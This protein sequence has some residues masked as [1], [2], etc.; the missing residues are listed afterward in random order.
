MDAFTNLSL[1]DSDQMEIDPQPLAQLSLT[2]NDRSTTTT[3]NTN[4]Y[5]N[6]RQYWSQVPS[7][8][9][10]DT[11]TTN[12]TLYIQPPSFS[13]ENQIES[14]V[15]IDI[16]IDMLSVSD[17]NIQTPVTK[18]EKEKD[19]I[20]EIEE[21]PSSTVHSPTVLHNILSPTQLG[22]FAAR[23]SSTTAITPHLSY[24]DDSNIINGLPWKDRPIH[25]SINNN[26]NNNFFYQNPNQKQSFIYEN[27]NGT[28]SFEDNELPAPWSAQSSPVSRIPYNFYSY[29][30]VT[31]NSLTGTLIIWF[32]LSSFKKDIHSLWY[33]DQRQLLL[34]SQSC[35]ENW[36]LNKCVENG[37]LPALTDQCIEWQ[38]CM[39]RDNEKL[40]GTRSL[41]IVSLLGQLVNEFIQPIGWKPI[42]IVLIGILSW[43]F[44]T[45]F[46]MGFLR[47]KYYYKQQDYHHQLK[48]TQ[49]KETA[50]SKSKSKSKT[51]TS[52]DQDHDKDN[53][54]NSR[55][56]QLVVT[57]PTT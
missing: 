32:L 42:I 33:S 29:L 46:L 9:R 6:S 50:K 45:N 8:Q 34:E 14:D 35:Q 43:L 10:N 18:K 7:P 2:D 13:Q 57:R 37:K 30:Q 5:T 36:N 55:E 40:F 25:V 41:R 56:Q 51:I 4:R 38:R 1:D 11:T 47:A 17:N 54:I 15:D 3:T 27:E 31:L 39:T 52:N 16:D 19:V 49:P 24:D 44:I 48:L 53:N 28:E 26:N 20:E 23:R 21:I 12:T 22:A